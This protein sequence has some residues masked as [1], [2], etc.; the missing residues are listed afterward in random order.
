MIVT[1]ISNSNPYLLSEILPGS[2]VISLRDSTYM[3]DSLFSKVHISSGRRP[4]RR[5]TTWVCLMRVAMLSQQI[6]VLYFR[7]AQV[8][9]LFVL[10]MCTSCRC[11]PEAILMI[12]RTWLLSGT[13]SCRLANEPIPSQPNAANSADTT[14]PSYPPLLLI[15]P[16]VFG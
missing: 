2:V 6:S 15:F 1:Y 3:T 7:S 12:V 9:K 10:R 16:Q 11:T 5:G 4:A 13:A 14:K 8:I